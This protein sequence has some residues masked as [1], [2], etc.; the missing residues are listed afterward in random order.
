M[1]A[2]VSSNRLMAA[3]FSD[4]GAHR[5]Y[6]S[7]RLS[8]A[9]GILL[10]I[11]LN[12]STATHEVDD[13]TIRKESKLTRALGFGLYEKVNLFGFRST[14]PRGLLTIENPWGDPDN[15]GAII[16]CARSASI[17]LCAWGH[18]P[19]PRAL[20]MIVLARAAAVVRSLKTEGIKMHVLALT[21]DGY[22]RHPLYLRDDVRPV[23]WDVAMEYANGS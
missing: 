6:L 21:K 3:A 1:K 23:P 10:S 19:S 12:P 2:L 9:P 7:R 18:Y 22:P 5:Y 8:A 4:D 13:N 20:S 11:G 16:G 14:N 15:L 17:V